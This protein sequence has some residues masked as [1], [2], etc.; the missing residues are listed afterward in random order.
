MENFGEQCG[1]TKNSERWRTKQSPQSLYMHRLEY[2]H[3]SRCLYSHWSPPA[4]A[5]LIPY[6]I[7]LVLEGMPLLLLEFAI[8]QRLR[9]GSVGVWRA[10]SPYL[11]GVGR[12]ICSGT[13]PENVHGAWE[14]VT[15]HSSGIAS[16]LVSLLVGLYYNTLIAWILWYLFN[17]FQEPLPWAQCPLNEN[18]TGMTTFCVWHEK[19]KITNSLQRSQYGI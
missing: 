7:L 11:T 14:N 6:L 13:K 10:I 1:E 12:W 15:L 17:S 9:K 4:G 16:M 2:L 3:Q 19:A 18:A 8:G 5:F